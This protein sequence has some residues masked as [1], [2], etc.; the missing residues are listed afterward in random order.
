MKRFFAMLLVCV[1]LVSVVLPTTAFAAENDGFVGSVEQKGDLDTPPKTGD[2]II[3][4]PM[5]TAVIFAV[6]GAV[7]YA[8][9]DR[10][11]KA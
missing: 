8:T 2:D 4:V 5:V 7:L 6:G 3:Y 11:Q 1:V 10:K 9:A